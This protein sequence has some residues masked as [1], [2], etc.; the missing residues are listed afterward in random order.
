MLGIP[1]AWPSVAAVGAAPQLD[2]FSHCRTCPS[3]PSSLPCWS[4]QRQIK[5]GFRL[6][7]KGGPGVRAPLGSRT[8]S[9]HLPVVPL[10]ATKAQGLQKGEGSWCAVGDAVTQLLRRGDVG[11]RLGGEQG[12]HGVSGETKRQRG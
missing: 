3:P 6:S 7:L 8:P 9:W 5:E 10:A 2:S 12:P 11:L 4:C 1:A